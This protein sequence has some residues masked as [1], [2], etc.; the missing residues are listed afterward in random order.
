LIERKGQSQLIEAARQLKAANIQVVLDFVGTGD[1]LDTYQ[2]EVAQ[3]G[4]MDLVTF[5]GYIPREEIS[6]F[7]QQAD[8]FV[9][10][11]Y[12]EGMSVATL[13]AMAAGL[14]VLVTRT[15]GSSDLV[16]EGINGHI[17][18]WGDVD[19]LVA[20]MRGAAEDRSRLA[21]M[22]A[23]SRAHAARFS[24]STAADQYLALFD[25]LTPSHKSFKKA[26]QA[27]AR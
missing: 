16:R 7:Y 9:L 19:R 22:G 10:P 6:A 12:N 24:W 5:H 20:L 4:L 1:A 25:A 23:A 14:A 3:A 18:D 27:M 8:I 17:F 2:A 15:G 21:V 26:E 11:S 13:E